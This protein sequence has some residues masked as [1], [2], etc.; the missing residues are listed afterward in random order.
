MGTMAPRHLHSAVRPRLQP[1]WHPLLALLVLIS[2]EIVPAA[3]SDRSSR[4]PRR[5]EG[6]GTRSVCAARLLA[7]L[8]PAEGRLALGK[9]PRLGLI[10]GPAPQ[11]APLVLRFGAS[12]LLLPPRAGASLR[13]VPLPPALPRA[14]AAAG[15]DTPWES[16][17]ACE[18]DGEPVA[19]PALGWLGSATSPADPRT[20]AA[21]ADLWR[22][23][24]TS[25]ATAEVLARF[26]YGHL[27]A[28]LPERLPVHCEVPVQA[29]E[30]GGSS[31]SSQTSSRPL[32]P[33][34][35]HAPQ[36]RQPA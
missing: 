26:G 2:I 6:G 15:W 10:E 30:G 25:V 18:G 34:M 13:L 36:A 5:R 20:E 16:F 28:Q 22:L 9:P 4:F 17:P 7:P 33:L 8:V 19:P 23:C 3:A 31:S 35:A 29:P 1:Q 32:R 27:Q 12:R 11:P 14:L 24:G 21:L